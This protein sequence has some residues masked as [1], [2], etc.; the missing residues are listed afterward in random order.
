M[1]QVLFQAQKEL[2]NYSGLGISVLGE[3]LKR[4]IAQT[5]CNQGFCL[6]C[7]SLLSGVG[8]WF[9]ALTIRTFKCYVFVIFKPEMSHRSSDFSKILNKAE[10]LL[11][12]LL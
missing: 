8:I 7:A 2:L 1:L 11:R 6:I 3:Q 12:E 10:S 5:L 9:Q 4:K